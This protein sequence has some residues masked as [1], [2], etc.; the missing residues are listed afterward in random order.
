[1]V[2]AE[3]KC[4]MCGHHFER[5]IIDEDEPRETRLPASPVRCPKCNSTFIEKIRWLRRAS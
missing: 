1:M 4:Q 2:V 5:K 3:L